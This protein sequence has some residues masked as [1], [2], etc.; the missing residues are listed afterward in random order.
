MK[1]Y[2]KVSIE[3]NLKLLTTLIYHLS[4]ISCSPGGLYTSIYTFSSRGK[5]IAEIIYQCVW[6][7]SLLLR[8]PMKTVNLMKYFPQMM[9]WQ[10]RG[11]LCA[12][13]CENNDGE[14][15]IFIV[16][17]CRHFNVILFWAMKL[18]TH[19]IDFWLFFA[20][21]LKMICYILGSVH[22]GLNCSGDLNPSPCVRAFSTVSVFKAV[23]SGGG[24]RGGE[25]AGY[26]LTQ[27]EDFKYHEK[28]IFKSLSTPS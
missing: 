2:F 15:N 19:E 12:V 14:E 10:M 3:R 4:M 16:L 7:K 1:K 6:H 27:G 24:G 18:F 11:T 26:F 25:I 9:D 20:D 23:R 22:K 8:A 5:V 21:E 13:S 28:K 17:V